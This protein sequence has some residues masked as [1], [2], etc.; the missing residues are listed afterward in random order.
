M[1]FPWRVAGFAAGDL[2][3]L[4]GVHLLAALFGVTFSAT[5]AVSFERRL[6]AMLVSIG[7]LGALV[8]LSFLGFIDPAYR[9][10]SYLNPFF[11]GI[12]PIGSIGNYRVGDFALPILGLLA[13]NL[14]ALLIGRRLAARTLERG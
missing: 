12:L 1:T 2:A 3:A 11:L 13:F 9:T 6:T 10:V 8:G 7:V 5:M 4:S 14:A